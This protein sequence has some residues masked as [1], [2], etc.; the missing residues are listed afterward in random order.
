MKKAFVLGGT[1]PH[2]DLINKLKKRGYY[3]I[4]IDYTDT[5]PAKQAADEHLKLSTLDGEAVLSVAKEYKIDLIITSCIDQANCVACYVAEKMGLPHPYSYESALDATKKGRM[6]HIFKENG[7]PT[8]DYYVL[9]A[10]DGSSPRLAYPIVIKPTDANSSKGVFKIT[11]DDEF[12]EKIK[13]SFRYSREGKV[14]VENFIQG[15]E[16]ESICMAVDGKSYV[17][18][19]REYTALPL[20]GKELQ[21][22]G[23][24]V[25]GVHCEAVRNQLEEISQKIVDAFHLKNTPFFLQGLYDGE[26]VYVMEF[27]SRISGGATYEMVERITGFDYLE[28]SI[29]SYLSEPIQV[30]IRRN[31]KKYS[32]GFLYMTPGVYDHVDGIQELVSEGKVEMWFPYSFAGKEISSSISTSNRL[33]SIM[34]SADT[35]EESSEKLK[36]VLKCIK[37]ID[38]SGNDVTMR[39][40]ENDK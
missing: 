40:W 4:L 3:V 21:T 2:I 35:Y 1:I 38:T 37:V 32:N 36:Q 8:A 15:I 13:E 14:I 12:H 16:M 6:K 27:A 34:V 22:A 23:S 24:S 30:A 5:P 9:D 20:S 18:M 31:E 39:K 33:G 25:P 19:T 11:S 29:K 26:K 10:D 28:A 17:L 7:I